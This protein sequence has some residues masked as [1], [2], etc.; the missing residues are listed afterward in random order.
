MPRSP[1]FDAPIR[2]K[3]VNGPYRSLPSRLAVTD[4][5]VWT[6]DGSDLFCLSFD[7][8][9][10]LSRRF[11]TNLWSLVADGRAA[12]VGDATGALYDLSSG[13]PRL[14]PGFT[15]ADAITAMALHE[16]LLCVGDSKGFVTV[17]DAD[18]KARWRLKPKGVTGV[19]KLFAD[20]DGLYL[21]TGTQVF[22]LDWSGKVRWR[23][24]VRKV[25]DACQGGSGVYVC[26]WG[27]GVGVYDAGGERVALYESR[28]ALQACAVNDDESRVF[29]G[30]QGAL[31]AWAA[32]RKRC[33]TLKLA[34]A[35][36]TAIACRGERLFVT[37]AFEVFLSCI[38]VSAKALAAAEKKQPAAPK[39]ITPPAPT[40]IARP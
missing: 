1:Y 14:V 17:L 6:F 16:G 3:F 15:S 29:A 21:A 40:P 22:A 5:R 37:T 19:A 35:L 13:E 38:D 31:V 28:G 11:P 33:W 39:V 20:A 9:L 4:D 8:E 27:D 2:W 12:Y 25:L 10:L 34:G 23:V 24:K 7:G 30:T 32:D 36:P 26:G 18:R